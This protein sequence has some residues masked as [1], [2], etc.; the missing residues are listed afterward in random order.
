MRSFVSL[1]MLTVV[2]CSGLTSVTHAEE[3]I[4]DNSNYSGYVFSPGFNEE[5]FDFGYTPGGTVSKFTFRYSNSYTPPNTIKVRF[6]RNTNSAYYDVGYFVKQITIY[7]VPY[8]GGSAQDYTH[9]IPSEDRFD[10]PSVFFGY[11]FECSTSNIN[12]GLASGGASQENELWDYD[13]IMGWSPFWFG[14][15]PWAGIYMQIYSS[16]PINDKT[17][18]IN[19]YKFDDVNGDG[20]WDAGEPGFPGWEIYLDINE[21]GQFDRLAEPNAV[22]D[23]NGMYLFENIEFVDPN[24]P[25]TFIIR[26]VMRSGWTQTLPGGPDNAYVIVAET[27]NV[28]G[29]YDF[30]NSTS[31]VTKYGGGY[32]T[33][34]DPYQIWTAEH[35]NQIGLYP[36]DWSSYFD[37]MDDIDLSGY[38][39]DSFNIIGSSST[40]FEGVFDGNGH[41]ISNF[42]YTADGFVNYVGLFVYVDNADA[43]IKNLTIDNPTISDGSNASGAVVGVLKN[44]SMTNCRVIGGSVTGSFRAG[45]LIGWIRSGGS[46]TESCVKEGSALSTND[47]CGGLVGV[48]EGS[49]SDCYSGFSATALNTRTGGVAGGN[50]GT[51]TNCYCYGPIY[52]DGSYFGGIAVNE[53]GSITA[54]FWDIQATSFWFEG[55]FDLNSMEM[56]IKQN[57]ID[58]GWD[59][60]GESDNGTDDIWDIYEGLERPYLSW[61]A[62]PEP[63]R[64]SGGSGTTGDPWQ[65]ATEVDLDT[66]GEKYQDWDNYFVL[67]A[68]IDMTGYDYKVIGDSRIDSLEFSGSFDGDGHT[69]S[70]VSYTG[71]D[72]NY[73]GLFGYVKSIESEIKDLGAINC[74]F[75]NGSNGAGCIVGAISSGRITDCWVEGGYTSSSFRS[76]GLVGYVGTDSIISG[77]YAVD[78]L[79]ET[80]HNH[81][82]GLAGDN[83][84]LIANCYSTYDVGGNVYLAGGFAGDNTGTIIN[85]YSTG[86]L[87]SGSGLAAFVPVSTGDVI[88]CFFDAS[89]CNIPFDGYATGM[90]TTLMMMES[91]F[92]SAGWD[93]LGEFD[94]GGEDVW[95]LCNNG[96]DYPRLS[97][98]F[99]VADI[100]CGD[101]IDLR[102]FSVLSG[103]WLLEDLSADVMPAGGDGIVNLADFSALSETW[104]LSDGDTGFDESCD[105]WPVDVGDGVIDT[106][107]L[108]VFAEQWLMKSNH[109]ADIAPA[110]GDEVVDMQDLLILAENWLWP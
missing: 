9:I 83:N 6:Y 101:G 60:V 48:N 99:N 86:R 24:V 58:A 37:L 35:M 94:N 42:T 69:I 75:I 47:Y 76:G 96:N 77:C 19:G 74:S 68:D 26:E 84:G 22:T 87:L 59:F 103:E 49:I 31:P 104:L 10:L 72:Q 98:Q 109:S 5:I 13:S 33:F 32:G 21:N 14:G 54:S 4:Y 63:V 106:E 51:I 12:L 29:P 23:I 100:S 17:C 41:T 61:E 67:T 85:C 46:V 44:G 91:T 50:T 18:E 11:S 62:L 79:T 38:T 30:G 95:R 53:G 93:M 40:P 102:D 105:L 90:I 39:G 82:G 7:D 64:Y 2:F 3:L 16:P 56:V 28:Y 108:N 81:A 88:G 73:V 71:D 15:D 45:G 80:E 107:D 92:L 25:E 57:F 27:N 52:I 8:T 43:E 70:N 55:D 1:S 78:G 34:A 66:L 36:G 89:T 97:H 20:V 110:G 65:I